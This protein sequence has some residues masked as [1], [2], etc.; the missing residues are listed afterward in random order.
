M[1]KFI[2]TGIASAIAFAVILSGCSSSSSDTPMQP[3][4]KH[5][6]DQ[7]TNPLPADNAID[8]PVST[9][10]S[11]ASAS[12]ATSYEVYLGLSA[13]SL[14]L[15]SS[16]TATIYDPGILDYS[17]EYCW[18]VDSVNADGTTA[19]AVWSLTTETTP[20]APPDQVTYTSPANNATD[21]SIDEDLLWSAATG[22]TSYDVYLGTNQT[23]VTNA[24]P[25]STEFQGSQTATTFDPGTLAFSTDYYWRVDSV[26]TYGSTAGPVWK[27]TTEAPPPPPDQ[28][29]YT[30]PADNATDVSID[31][32][33]VWSAAA[34]ATSYD[35]YFGTNQTAVTNATPGS[36]DFQGSQ[37]AT[38]YDPGTLGYSTDYY[39]RVDSVNAYGMTA[40]AV[41]KFTTAAPP[42][43]PDQ[44]T[45][46]SP[47]D[48]VTGVSID[49]DLVW[50]AATGATSYD[51]YFGTNQTDV[52]NATP[53]ST[54]FQ[55]SQTA[56]TFDP[57]TLNYSTD[58]YW[59]VD[60]VN[61][62][63]TTAGPVWKFTTEAPPPP[64][65]Q[66]TYLAP[67]NNAFDVSV[68]EDLVWSAATG[69]TSYD[70]YFGTNQSAVTNA[71]PGST[72]FQGSQ[73][74]T[75]CDP[76]ALDY[77]TDYYWRVDSVNAY[78]TTA[79][80][81][82]HFTTE[83]EPLPPAQV[84]GPS[85][86]HNETGVSISAS[87]SWNEA[88][89]ATSYEV[90]TGPDPGSLSLQISQ[91]TTAFNP[92]LLDYSTDYY[93]RIDSVNEVDTTTGAVWHF[94][95]E[96]AP[97][98]AP[99][100]PGSPDPPDT[101]TG[102]SVEANITWGA[103]A[104]ADY[105]TI[106]FGPSTIF[107]QDMGS[108]TSTTFDLGTLEYSKTYYW[109]ILAVNAVDT[110]YGPTWEFT[111]EAA[112]AAAPGQASSPLPFDS[113]TGVSQRTA[114]EWDAAGGA[115]SYDIYFGTN[116]TPSTL[117]GTQRCTVFD[118]GV[119]NPSTTYYWRVNARNGFGPTAGPVWEFTTGPAA[120]GAGRQ[121]AA[122]YPA[123]G[124]M[125]V[126][127]DAVF[128]WLAVKRALSYDVYFGTTTSPAFQGNQTQHT[129]G[130]GGLS[131]STMYY[132][133]VDVVTTTGTVTGKVMSFITDSA[134]PDRI[135][136]VDM[137]RG[138]DFNNGFSWSQAVKSIS[139]AI[140]LAS[141]DWTVLVAPGTYC[142]PDNTD[143]D[144]GDKSLRIASVSSPEM[145]VIHGNDTARC[146]NM[147]SGWTTIRG[148][149]IR[150][151]YT[152]GQGGGI[153][154][155]NAD[156]VSVRHC[157][158][159]DCSAGNDAG[160]ICCFQTP[161]AMDSCVVTDNTSGDYGGAVYIYNAGPATFTDSVFYANDAVTAG[162][163]VALNISPNSVFS[164]C[165]FY[166][167]NTTGASSNGGALYGADVNNLSVKS[168]TFTGNSSDDSGGSCYFTSSG[169]V[170]VLDSI[171]Y[172]STSLN[173]SFANELYTSISCTMDYCDTRFGNANTYGY[174]GTLTLTHCIED[175]PIFAYG[176][177]G[178]YYLSALAAGQTH[179][180]PCINAGSDTAV[181]LGLS[182][183]TTRTDRVLDTGTA[184]IGYH[185]DP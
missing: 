25:G 86:A 109:Q 149:T 66:V 75:T 121:V 4:Q 53:G 113:S 2:E 120:S 185:Y 95:T 42:P 97:S 56:T 158:V 50:S 68:D 163:A 6:P 122:M 60:S 15:R 54:E 64:P 131:N 140:E 81:V 63:G 136:Y 70:V 21:V 134:S 139:L 107:M 100:T 47:A 20:V 165:L 82:W 152:T 87:L 112:P 55:G 135:V 93:W 16:Q 155:A 180:S 49:E 94:T 171:M 142:G 141:N 72:E 12:G 104:D 90:Y 89:G 30:S 46:T 78:G 85:P 146:F 59:R 137:L 51:V 156:S 126:P 79:G 153:Y 34:G 117:V 103:A 17:T 41:W 166:D 45:Y 169:S 111:T 143:L 88:A 61:A 159:K 31:E 144:P 43:P 10:L 164:N 183:R 83:D 52:T 69:A 118:P 13:G 96:A 179:D 182:G 58:Y 145:T 71:T 39:W 129:F 8:V 176:P 32:N 28:V 14:S 11:W 92:G 184:D 27:F 167:N 19:G 37:T 73:T 125:H 3:V 24:T 151:G 132:W 148:F 174:G 177:S 36:T 133:R 106:F 157:I 33:L 38:T 29:T 98:S 99:G 1:G 127:V 67:A 161:L 18:R 168:C 101:A 114:L 175:N 84:T 138:S 5:P 62:Y 76:G 7:V 173:S 77:F 110:T 128:D 154:C 23:A 130:P 105:Y 65:D 108:Q 9:D 178:S 172:G 170:T 26:N 80:A 74:A 91:E 181:N 115:D 147:S 160:A 150:N 102:V 123:D 44:V 162:G 48:S 35:I 116:P 57:G 40:G 22:A 124:A 119:L